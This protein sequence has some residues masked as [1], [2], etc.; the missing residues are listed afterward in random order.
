M[1]TLGPP[2]QRYTFPQIRQLWIDNGGNPNLADTMAGIAIAESGGLS[3]NLNNSGKDYSVGLWQINY[4]GSM[5]KG[6]TASYGSPEALAGDVNKQAKAAISLAGNGAG[7]NNW[8]TFTSG[9][10][11]TPVR[12]ATGSLGALPAIA[13]VAAGGQANVSSAAPTTDNE[14]LLIDL[15]MPSAIPNI[16]VSR[17]AVRKVLGGGVMVT[18]GIVGLAGTFLLLGGEAPGVSGVVQT[19]VRQRGQTTRAQTREAG[20]SERQERRSTMSA[21]RDDLAVRRRARQAKAEGE[22][23]SARAEG[24]AAAEAAGDF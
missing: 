1:S 5:L 16:K 7:L 21:E 14:G 11:K 4:Y 23:T 17:A 19:A 6:R 15:T 2:G 10:Y 12:A 13:G 18:G 24:R 20:L 22:T 3:N 8:T 9:A